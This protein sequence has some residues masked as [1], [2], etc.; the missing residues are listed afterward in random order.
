[1]ND[2]TMRDLARLVEQLDAQLFAKIFQRL[3]G[4]AFVEHLR[5][6]GPIFEIFVVRHSPLEGDRLVLRPAEPFANDRVAALFVFNDVGTSL[7]SAHFADAGNGG[8]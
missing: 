7:E 4:P 6:V 2:V 8:S 5:R 3:R 1:M